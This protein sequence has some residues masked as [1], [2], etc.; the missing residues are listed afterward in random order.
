MNKSIINEWKFDRIVHN[1]ENH[2]REMELLAAK[3]KRM[4]LETVNDELA[5]KI[6]KIIKNHPASLETTPR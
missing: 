2:K 5:E 3:L 4:R 1:Y 6:K